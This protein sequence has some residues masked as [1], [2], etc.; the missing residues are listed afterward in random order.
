MTQEELADRIL[1]EHEDANEY[2][3]YESDREWI[4]EA[5]MEFAN[6]VSKKP[7]C[8]CEKTTQKIEHD[9]HPYGDNIM[10]DE[11][12]VCGKKHNFKCF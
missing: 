3:F 12:D 8:A 11:C 2:H 10:Y 5:M 9:C 7:Q 6:E 4:I 1:S